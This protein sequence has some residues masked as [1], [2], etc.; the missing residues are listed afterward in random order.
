[1]AQE[2]LKELIKNYCFFS[3]TIDA[4]MAVLSDKYSQNEV[5]AVYEANA[6]EQWECNLSAGEDIFS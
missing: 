5:L 2:I 1:M 3:G 6:A 4:A